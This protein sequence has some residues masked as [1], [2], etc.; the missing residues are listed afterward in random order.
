VNT[1]TGH[2]SLNVPSGRPRDLPFSFGR[3][4]K[5][6]TFAVAMSAVV[7]VAIAMLLILAGRH[8][9]AGPTAALQREESRMP[10]KDIVWL[11]QPGPSGGG[12]GGGSRMQDPPRRVELPGKDR[13]T[14]PIAEPAAIDVAQVRNEPPPIVQLNIPAKELASAQDSLPGALDV[15]ALA[16]LS[17]GSGL[18]GGAETGRGR[19]IGPGT[20]PGLGPGRDGGTGGRSFQPGNGVTTPVVLREVKPLYTSDAMRAKVQGSVLLECVV[21]PDGSVG[22][23]RVVRSL[24][25][26][27]GLDLEAMKAASQWRFRP[28]LRLGESVPVLITIQLD[29]TLR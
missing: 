15:P 2:L 24:D 4:P 27:F 19:G 26:R 25:S 5:R 16:T 1:S 13:L 20:G 14:V 3:E 10:I 7:D 23:V 6:L 17:Q 12:G 11:S 29:F 8:Q 28:G 9:P 18:G 22:D 21:R